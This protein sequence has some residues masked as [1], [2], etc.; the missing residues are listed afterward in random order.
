MKPENKTLPHTSLIM[1]MVTST[2][3]ESLGDQY[4]RRQQQSKRHM[5]EQKLPGMTSMK[6]LL[7]HMKKKKENKN[8]TSTTLSMLICAKKVCNYIQWQHT[9]FYHDPTIQW[10]AY[11]YLTSV[12]TAKSNTIQSICPNSGSISGGLV[13]QVVDSKSNLGVKRTGSLQTICSQPWK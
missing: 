9:F 12:R 7:T 11:Q 13:I 3:Q 6:K 10:Q 2:L 4:V 5:K 8:K 1:F